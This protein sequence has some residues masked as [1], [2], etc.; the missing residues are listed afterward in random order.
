MRDSLTIEVR[1]KTVIKENETEQEAYDRI[2]D[3]LFDSLCKDD[4]ETEFE[5]LESYTDCPIYN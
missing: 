3:K 2:Y 5:F 4:D 1:I